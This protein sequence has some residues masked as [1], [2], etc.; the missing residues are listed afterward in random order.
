MAKLDSFRKLIR[1]EVRAVFQEELATILKEAII[2][3]KHTITEAVAPRKAA[4]PGTLNTQPVR[5]MAAPILSPNNPLNSLLAETANDMSGEDMRSLN[6]D[7]SDA[8]GFGYM[9]GG[10][11]EAPVVDSV[12]GMFAAARPS[13]NMDAIQINAVPDF[14]A[15]M[16]KM[17]QN[18]E[19]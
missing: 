16:A 6:F 17:Q 8:Q 13:S 19:V 14:T 9:Q 10:G 15:L 12:G 2:S 18:G 7:S 3:N 4:V 5:K 11:E 1:E